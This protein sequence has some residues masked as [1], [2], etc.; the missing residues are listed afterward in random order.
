[1]VFRKVLPNVNEY[2]GVANTPLDLPAGG[3]GRVYGITW[4]RE[5]CPAGNGEGLVSSWLI[6][7]LDQIVYR[8]IEQN[9]TLLISC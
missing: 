7:Q 6:E 3:N 9:E 8:Y 5:Q 4:A 1:M 2:G